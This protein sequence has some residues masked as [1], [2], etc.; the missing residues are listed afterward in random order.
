MKKAIFVLTLFCI[1]MIPSVVA[2]EPVEILITGGN[3]GYSINV[4]INDGET[5]CITTYA[6]TTFLFN[7]APWND[8]FKNYHSE[9]YLNA[10]S[11]IG[12]GYY[13]FSFGKITVTAIADTGLTITRS[14]F[15]I[16]GFVVLGL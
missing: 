10:S 6:N 2:E 11:N 1:L 5:H 14:G 7:R 9:S 4:D 12:G 8:D 15:I 3:L 16:S 13:R